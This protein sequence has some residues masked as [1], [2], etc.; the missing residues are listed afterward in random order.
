MAYPATPKTWVAGDVLTAAQLNAEL[1]D[2]LLGAF[3]L[4]P[5]DG[6][7]TSY[8]P[9]LTQS[10]TVTKTAT[11]AKYTR[12]GRTIIVQVDLAVT[13]AGTAANAVVVG[14]P[15]AAAITGTLKVVG[16]GEIYDA[17]AT[18]GY[19]GVVEIVT[20]TTVCFRATNTTVINAYLGGDSFVAALAAGDVV[21]MSVTYE[22]ST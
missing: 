19:R 20:S 15:V 8:T 9:T 21:S 4:G 11:Y 13:G 22:S 10:A 12:I 18:L 6:A 17:S 2:A 16:V 3:P 5:P 7:W 14:L 1:R